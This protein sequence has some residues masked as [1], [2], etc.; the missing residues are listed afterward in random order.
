LAD[1]YEKNQDYS[2]AL[3]TYKK[4][5][6]LSVETGSGDKNAYQSKMEDLALLLKQ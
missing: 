2:S 6:D 1:A 4:A 3:A 5:Y